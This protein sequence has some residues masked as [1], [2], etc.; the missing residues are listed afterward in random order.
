LRRIGGAIPVGY[1]LMKR[2]IG[3]V[4]TID[5]ILAQLRH[6]R[7]VLTIIL[8]NLNSLQT[9]FQKVYLYFSGQ[10]QEIYLQKRKNS[11]LW[12]VLDLNWQEF[13][14]LKKV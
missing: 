3:K 5:C 2:H 7:K 10:E 4:L 11:T 9:F 8:A 12:A 14:G 13:V 6:F 1:L